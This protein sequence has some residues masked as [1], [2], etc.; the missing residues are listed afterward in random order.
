MSAVP[1]AVC[2]WDTVKV[3][4]GSR[5]LILGVNRGEPVPHFSFF[6]MSLMTAK[7]SISEPVAARVSTEYTG[8]AAFIFAGAMTRSHGSPSYL[9][10]PATTF[11]QSMTLPP[12]MAS[13]MSM[14]FSLQISTPFLTDSIL[15]FG[16]TP[17]S[18]KTSSP[19]SFNI[20]I[21]SSYIPERLMLPP[22]YTMSTLFPLSLSSERWLIWPFPKLMRVGI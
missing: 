7:V 10:P 13:T 19:A 8:R 9:A 11:A 5:T 14:Q 17:D 20:F 1:A 21:A 4:V 6:D 3:Y 18:S 2:F 15:G 16:S 12:P 22:P